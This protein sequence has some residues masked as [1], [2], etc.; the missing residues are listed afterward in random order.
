LMRV[1][2]EDL[3]SNRTE[4]PTYCQHA[5]SNFIAAIMVE[6][7]DLGAKLHTAFLRN[8]LCYGDGCHSTGLS[9]GNGFTRSSE[10]GFKEVLRQ[11]SGLAAASF[12]HN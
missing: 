9:A 2:A 4:Y 10:L 7:A 8:A 5:L 6:P 12:A 11:L 1:A 3:S